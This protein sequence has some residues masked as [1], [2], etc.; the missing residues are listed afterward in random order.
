MLI[1]AISMWEC[2]K[3]ACSKNSS[4]TLTTNGEIFSWGSCLYG[5]LG[6][7][8]SSE[9]QYFPIQVI[10]NDNEQLKFIDISCGKNHAAAISIESKQNLYMW[11]Q[12]DKG[13]LGMSDFED[14]NVPERSRV[15][16][17]VLT[18]GLG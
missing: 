11:G 1:E 12:N 15:C 6:I 10:C 7:G 5:I 9:N 14:R 3:V 8:D 13:Q 4:F 18:L 17:R 2:R 16:E